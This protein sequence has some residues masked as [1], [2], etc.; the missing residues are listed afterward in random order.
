MTKS[1]V[2]ADS[3]ALCLALVALS[4]L[5]GCS[6]RAS[7]R[8][9]AASDSTVMIPNQ[10]YFARLQPYLDSGYTVRMRPKGYS[11]LPTINDRTD[12]VRLAR[13][14]SLRLWDVVLA[15][16]EPGHY[17]LHRVMRID[18]DTLI[19]KGD[20]NRTFEWARRNQVRATLTALEHHASGIRPS[21]VEVDFGEDV[22][23]EQNRQVL[24]DSM[25]GVRFVV[26]RQERLVDMGRS[27][28]LNESAEVIWQRV[29]QGP[30]T[31]RHLVDALREEYEVDVPTA[32]ADC[33]SMLAAWL[34]L[35]LVRPVAREPQVILP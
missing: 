23:F 18:G 32:T 7:H 12:M 6:P 8:P 20:H 28:R 16:I 1:F 2:S 25:A 30:F 21:A 27:I 24:I 3:L 10:A 15:E 31:L 34:Q 14:D 13:K 11:M 17:V 26:D 19:L 5:T 9:V 22:T 33:R 29:E 35:D 4:I